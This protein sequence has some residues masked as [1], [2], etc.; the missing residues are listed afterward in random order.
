MWAKTQAQKT[1]VEIPTTISAT[2]FF[3]KLRPWDRAN[4]PKPSGRSPEGRDRSEES[5]RT[6]IS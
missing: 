4:G 1:V 3:N 5:E 6:T 2:H